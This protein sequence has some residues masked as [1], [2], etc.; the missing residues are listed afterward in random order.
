MQL[1][2]H[3]VVYLAQKAW[4]VGYFLRMTPKASQTLDFALEEEL[5][6]MLYSP[7]ESFTSAISNVAHSAADC[8]AEVMIMRGPAGERSEESLNIKLNYYYLNIFIMQ[9]P[10]PDPHILC[11]TQNRTRIFNFFF[12]NTTPESLFL[13]VTR[14]VPDPMQD[15]PRIIRLCASKMQTHRSH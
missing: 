12:L 13:R 6:T 1:L 4:D 10:R 15:S 11:F 14:R 2:T 9:H 7:L 5:F 8:G 3:A